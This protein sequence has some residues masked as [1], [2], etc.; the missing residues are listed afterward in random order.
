MDVY[1]SIRCLK[2]TT[3]KQPFVVGIGAFVNLVVCVKLDN[4]E[5]IVLQVSEDSIDY[6]LVIRTLSK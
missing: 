1:R 6:Q 2:N 3:I 5:V 4:E